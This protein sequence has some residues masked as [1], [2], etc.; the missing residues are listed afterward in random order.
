MIIAFLL[1]AAVGFITAVL[2]FIFVTFSDKEDK[3]NDRT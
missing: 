3:Q 2:G 1:G